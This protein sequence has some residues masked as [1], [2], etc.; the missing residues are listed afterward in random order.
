MKETVKQRMQLETQ[1]MRRYEKH[2]KF[3]QQNLVF[4]NDAKKFYRE[5]EKEE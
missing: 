5:I 2:G 4:K 3:Y 1:R